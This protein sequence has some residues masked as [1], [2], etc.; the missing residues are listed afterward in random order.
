M[1]SAAR[2]EEIEAYAAIW[3][4]PKVKDCYQTYFDRERPP[5]MD[6]EFLPIPL[7][8][9]HGM[10]PGISPDPVGR[11][12][13]VWL[14]DV[15]VKFRA[16]LDKTSAAYS[17][18]IGE[19]R[20]GLLGTSSGVPS[21]LAE[22]ADDG[23]FVRWPI[24]EISLTT[25][26][27]EERIP[28]VVA[29]RSMPNKRL[30]LDISSETV[31]Q[32]LRTGDLGDCDCEEQ[33]E[34]NEPVPQSP[35]PLLSKSNEDKMLTKN[36]R[37]IQ[38]TRTKRD[39]SVPAQSASG[40]GS[41]P[42]GTPAAATP[43]RAGLTLAML[44]LDDSATPADV[45][46]AMCGLLGDSAAAA[47]MSDAMGGIDDDVDGMDS[48]VDD[49]GLDSMDEE[50]E[51]PTGPFDD[52]E[53]DPRPSKVSEF[54][55]D[56]EDIDYTALNATAEKRNTQGG[57]TDQLQRILSR[58]KQ[59][60]TPRSAPRTAS[61]SAG[62]DELI[63]LQHENK[64]L[65]RELRDAPVDEPRG[66]SSVNS[67]RGNIPAMRNFNPRDLVYD[68]SSAADLSFAIR[69]LEAKGKPVSDSL[70]RAATMKIA[71]EI[72]KGT[73][74]G[75]DLTV[76]YMT[77]FRTRNDVM[78]SDIRGLRRMMAIRAGEVMGDTNTNFG[79]NY[80]GVFY[81]TAL[82]LKV[83]AMPIW[84]EL[85][86]RGME[87]KVIPVG[88][89][90]DVIPLEGADFSWYRV[91]E[92]IDIDVSG[93]P[94]INIP[95]SKAGTSSATLTVRTL[96]ALVYY[97]VLVEE[98]S[99]VPMAAELNRKANLEAQ[100][101]IENVVFNGDTATGTTNI[102]YKNGTLAT[103]DATNFTVADGMLKAGIY[104]NAGLNARQSSGLSELD[105][106]LL[107]ALL[108][109]NG[110][111][112]SDPSKLLFVVDPYTGLA[113]DRLPIF[114]TPDVA[115]PA[116][117]LN[118]KV[119]EAWGVKIARSGQILPAD[120]TGYIDSVTPANNKYGRILLVRPDQWVIGFKRQITMEFF[121][122]V[123]SQ[124]NGMTLTL[125]V[126]LQ[127]RD[128]TQAASASYAVVIK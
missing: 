128:A 107:F 76:Q 90:S 77:P 1:R 33:I 101:Q 66:G 62:A 3:G 25:T 110:I 102:N 9:G 55:N 13:Q 72:E 47:V 18:I 113:S 115:N 50:R 108:N 99:I 37:A 122:D 111:T 60:I 17:R 45:F 34:R 117:I 39:N 61:H 27:C 32:A 73:E 36:K 28:A 10:E 8:Y 74:T 31:G 105:Y 69:V 127:N 2:P 95:P 54:S 43:K 5:K 114:K 83:R 80:V 64:R 75:S 15:G 29:V 88:F 52:P 121:R 125:R 6:L 92:T 84:R 65:R 12:V 78:S 19:I 26:P 103:T 93:R 30:E 120:V 11:V 38:Q 123:P 91:P 96:G 100:E 57:L 124:S 81:D 20:D 48:S 23:R 116:T 82:W 119:M 70:Y 63:R 35:K 104:G 49:T 89:A 59:Q 85:E 109:N 41:V 118:G 68:G 42:E 22:F 106:Q 97:S 94:K 126:G 51:F 71:G 112:G 21:Y 4:S 58:Q 98:D 46:E 16:I 86:A 44:G 14:D 67:P 40:P 24:A 56:P 7:R 87:E 53:T 79:S